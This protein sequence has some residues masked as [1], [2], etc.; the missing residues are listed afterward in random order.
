MEEHRVDPRVV[1]WAA[2]DVVVSAAEAEELKSELRRREGNAYRDLLFS[3]THRYFSLEQSKELWEEIL[4][5]KAHMN[6]MIGR[7]VGI[8]VAAADYLTN[9]RPTVG[10]TALIAFQDVSVLAEVALKDGLTGLYDHATFF[11]KLHSELERHWRYMVGFSLIVLDIDDFK[12]LNDRLGH[13]QGDRALADLARVITSEIRRTDVAARYG[14]EEFAVI[15]THDGDERAHEVAERIRGRVERDFASRFGM[16]VSVGLAH[17]P[18]HGRSARELIAH[19]DAALYAAKSSGKNTVRCAG[20]RV[21]RRKE[22]GPRR[23]KQ[24]PARDRCEH[25]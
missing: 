23:R 19:A 11:H 18:R 10:W 24:Q 15:L 1:A 6:E 7:N 22:A 2:G 8:T 5:H 9:V 13:Q 25:E 21:L 4:R 16:T 17:C 12:S 14:G 20:D 3:L